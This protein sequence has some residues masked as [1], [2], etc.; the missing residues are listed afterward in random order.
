LKSI[1][2]AEG[3]FH[4]FPFSVATGNTNFSPAMGQISD[5]IVDMLIHN[6]NKMIAIKLFTYMMEPTG[7]SGFGGAR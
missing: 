3:D 7:F 1:N 5:V 2:L 4:L 6:I